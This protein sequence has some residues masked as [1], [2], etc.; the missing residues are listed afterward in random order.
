[1]TDSIEMTLGPDLEEGLGQDYG[2]SN[3][4]TVNP[5]VKDAIVQAL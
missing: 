3:G 2:I 4:P 5:K 1:M